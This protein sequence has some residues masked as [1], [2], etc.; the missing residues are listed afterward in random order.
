[1]TYVLHV[2]WC[3]KYGQISE[4]INEK[5]AKTVHSAFLI[6]HTTGRHHSGGKEIRRAWI[7]L[8]TMM[9]GSLV[10]SIKAVRV[11]SLF[12]NLGISS[13]SLVRPVASVTFFGFIFWGRTTE[14]FP[15]NVGTTPHMTR[16]GPVSVSSFTISLPRL[17]FSCLI[18]PSSTLALWWPTSFMRSSIV[19]SSMSLSTG[20][21]YLCF[22]PSPIWLM[23]WRDL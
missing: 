8:T 12:N 14:T 17:S 10:T 18:P 20:L 13:F 5:L 2:V 6:L 7:Q 15:C 9:G 4:I 22:V 11:I 3:V 1:M 21:L 19:E 23:L 16:L